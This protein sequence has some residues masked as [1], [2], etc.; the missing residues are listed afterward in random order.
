M[1]LIQVGIVDTT[2]KLDPHLVSEA[3]AAINVQVMRDLPQFWNIQATVRALPDAKQIPSGVWPVKLVKSL[4]PGEGGFHMTEHNQPYAKVIA[5]PGDETWTID[6]SHEIIE[7]LVDPDGNRLQSSKSI[8]IVGDAVIDGN[9]EFNYLV[10]AC[11]PCEANVFAYS[12]QGIA[13][14][15]F[16]TPHFY[17]PV[18]TPGTRYSFNG[19][20]TGPRE[21]LQGGYISFINGTEMQ[22][23]LWVDPSEPPQL[24]NLGRVSGG[25]LRVWIDNHTENLVRKHKE[26]NEE[27]MSAANEHRIALRKL[28]A[29]HAKFYK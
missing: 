27:L 29:I 10:E 3:A 11:D 25:S 5:T 24:R 21:L 28:A 17:D 2:G 26:P 20:C 4:P 13:V 16:I 1:S 9:G 19:S 7:M 14:S 12:I 23:I 6:A 8:K 15:D 22:Q 18:A